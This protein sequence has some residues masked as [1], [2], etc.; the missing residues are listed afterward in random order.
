MEKYILN[1]AR[2]GTNKVDKDYNKFKEKGIS[3]FKEIKN[4]NYTLSSINDKEELIKYYKANEKKI[5]KVIKDIYQLNY[6]YF[7]N[8][9]TGI[10]SLKH[11]TELTNIYLNKINE[12]KNIDD[13]DVLS[14]TEIILNKEDYDSILRNDSLIKRK[15]YLC[16]ELLGFNKLEACDRDHAKVLNLVINSTS[17]DKDHIQFNLT[18]D[19][20][21]ADIKNIINNDI[22]Y[23]CAITMQDTHEVKIRYEKYKKFIIDNEEIINH[24]QLDSTIFYKLEKIFNS[25]GFED[26]KIISAIGFNS[27]IIEGNLRTLLS[28][29]SYSLKDKSSDLDKIIKMKNKIVYIYFL[30]KVIHLQGILLASVYRLI[31]K[32]QKINLSLLAK[33]E[34]LKFSTTI[35]AID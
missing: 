11:E 18:L 13:L 5:Y 7:L 32:T 2:Q 1:F 21:I 28:T 3:L 23:N 27:L 29:L 35:K 4:F 19:E 26:K 6:K 9:K 31:L 30:I 16:K 15:G 34:L 8:K 10:H 24:Y 20:D 33:I 25:L 22:N 12:V 17:Y 14:E